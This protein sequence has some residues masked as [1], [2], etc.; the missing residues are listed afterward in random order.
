MC[1]RERACVCV[2]VCVFVGRLVGSVKKENPEIK[3]K[4]WWVCKG[5]TGRLLCV[6]V[7]EREGEKESEGEREGKR[8]C[9]ERDKNPVIKI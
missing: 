8:I 9:I 1:E 5:I 4:K 3:F 6:F 2:C 7:C